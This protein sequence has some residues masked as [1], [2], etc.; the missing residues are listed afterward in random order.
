MSQDDTQVWRDAIALFETLSDLPPDQRAALLGT[1][2]AAVRERARKM[3]AAGDVA[4][5]LDKPLPVDRPPQRL[6]RWEIGELLGQGGM[7]RVYRARS[8]TAPVGQVAAVKL[9]AVPAPGEDLL[10]RFSRETE[11]LVR[12]QHPGIAPLLDAGVAADGRPWFAMTLAEGQ[13]IDAW[14]QRGALPARDRVRLVRQVAD[15]VAHAHRLLIVHRDIKPGNVMV[16]ARGR[17]VLL[18][19]GISRVLEEGAAE[20]TSGG[21]YPFTPRYAAP[22]QREGGAIS[23]ATDVYGL[24]A[25]L[26]KLLLDE[27]PALGPDGE[28][29]MP[30]GAHLSG[31]LD[32]ILRKALARDPRDRYAGAAEFGADLDAW[33]EVRPVQARRGGRVYRLRR[34]VGRNPTLAAL[35]AALAAS[36]VIGFGAST[37]QASATWKAV[38]CRAGL[39]SFSASSESPR[40]ASRTSISVTGLPPTTQGEGSVLITVREFFMV[41]LE[42]VLQRA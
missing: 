41:F 19:F 24:G 12:L 26:Y 23:T 8:A 10:A 9:L 25:L 40:D 35:S 2:P 30:A 29:A 27:A 7:S 5:P 39:A 28:L 37:W 6:G 34:W 18:D 1:V 13:Q 31:D 17:A 42:T 11:I 16:D 38:G 21:S 36:L 20:L 15:A 3:L 33:L 22:E 4:G 14:C 32:A